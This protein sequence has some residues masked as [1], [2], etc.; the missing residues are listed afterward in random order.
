[1]LLIGVIFSTFQGEVRMETQQVL[2]RPDTGGNEKPRFDIDRGKLSGQI[3][4]LVM[5]TYLER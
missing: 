1:M 3:L 4:G 5:Y 2:V